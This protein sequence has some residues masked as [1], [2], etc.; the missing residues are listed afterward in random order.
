MEASAM[1]QIIYSSLA[2]VGMFA[3]ISCERHTWEDSSEGAKDGTKRLY[4][5][6]EH[7]KHG[8]HAKHDGDADH[9]KHDDDSAHVHS[10]KEESKPVH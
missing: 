10:K 6:T 5:K 2:I 8:D 4:P 1:K 9:A 7:A 3:F